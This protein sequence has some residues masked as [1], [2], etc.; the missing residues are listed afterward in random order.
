MSSAR[1]ASII[2]WLRPQRNTILLSSGCICCTVRG[3]LVDTLRGLFAR[4]RKGEIP[5]FDRIVIETTGLADPVPILQT[6]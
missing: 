1:S 2:C 5:A 6:W 4:R 3:D